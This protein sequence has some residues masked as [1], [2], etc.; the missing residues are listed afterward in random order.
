MV[1]LKDLND[2][3]KNRIKNIAKKIIIRS[4]VPPHIADRM[5]AAIEGQERCKHFIRIL[6][7]YSEWMVQQMQQTTVM[8]F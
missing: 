2:V 4:S 1:T 8:V 5:C 6:N 7:E 3:V